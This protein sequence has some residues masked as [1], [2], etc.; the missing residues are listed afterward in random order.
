M[1]GSFIPISKPFI[2]AREKELVLDAL[3]SGRADKIAG[4]LGDLLLQ[5]VFHAELGR[6]AGRFD[7]GDVIGQVHAKMVRRHPHVF[8]DARA[9]TSGEVLKKWEQL[10]SPA[11][12]KRMRP[13]SRRAFPTFS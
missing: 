10:P 12:L 6:E 1:S 3:D 5:V 4:E 11:K 9:R 2:G 8:G 7:I 13:P